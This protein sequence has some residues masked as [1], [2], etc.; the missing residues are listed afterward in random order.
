MTAAFYA[1][2]LACI[3]PAVRLGRGID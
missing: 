3:A 1:V 2:G